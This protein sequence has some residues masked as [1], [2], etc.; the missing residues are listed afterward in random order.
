MARPAERYPSLD[1]C[2]R[3]WPGQI[4]PRRSQYPVAP[5]LRRGWHEACRRQRTGAVIL[6]A[7]HLQS[8][9]HTRVCPLLFARSSIVLSSSAPARF[10]NPAPD[11]KATRAPFQ[12]LE[13]RALLTRSWLLYFF[14]FKID[15]PHRLSP[16]SPPR[17][18][19]D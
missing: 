2:G 3:A 9:S 5:P 4:G 10:T 18:F 16:F 7:A 8:R 17:P 15:A 1:L 14:F 11:I 12:P 19:P 13:L 6:D